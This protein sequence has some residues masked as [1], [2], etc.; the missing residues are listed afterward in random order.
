MKMNT[1]M[2]VACLVAG[3]LMIPAM[4]YAEDSDMEHSNAKTYVKDSVITAKVK[5][6]GS[7]SRVT[8]SSNWASSL[9][10]SLT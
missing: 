2:M 4:G 9:I 3:A 6:I 5:V 7:N 8:L 10:I 1:K